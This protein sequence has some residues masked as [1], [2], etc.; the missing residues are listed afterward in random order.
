MKEAY[1]VNDT[2]TCRFCGIVKPRTLEFFANN[3]AGLHKTCRDCVRRRALDK[4]ERVSAPG[5]R[6][7][8]AC[9][10][11]KPATREFFSANRRAA[12]G[13][14]TH[15]KPC[16]AAYKRKKRAEDPEHVR[17]VARSRYAS[18]S[19]EILAYQRQMYAER[20]RDHAVARQREWRLRNPGYAGKAARK[21]FA[22]NPE[23]RREYV[24]KNRG[25]IRRVQ[26]A[27]VE[28]NRQ[29]IRLQARERNVR[30]PEVERAKRCRRK[31][32]K[33]AAP[34][35]FTA[36]ELALQFESQRGKC[37][38][39]GAHLAEYHADH[40][41]P[42]ARTE[43]NPTNWIENIVCACPTCNWQ[44]CDRTPEEWV[45]RWYLENSDE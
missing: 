40:V 16:S 8:T 7:C 3:G 10:I 26:R 25:R 1:A 27:Y 13:C 20:Y 34:G 22:D 37:F 5:Q 2:C 12:D 11:A 17:A 38:Y 18:K 19:E 28:R 41:I 35:A 29:R 39:C 44:K 15:C 43:L 21:F 24:K 6:V 31:A 42:L 30:A 14:H 36:E 23:W 33:L 45:D 32:R 4:R 9:G